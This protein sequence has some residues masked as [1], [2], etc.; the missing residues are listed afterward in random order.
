MKAAAWFLLLLTLACPCTAWAQPP[1]TALRLALLLFPDAANLRTISTM[2]KI[3][4]TE[5]TP[6]FIAGL[7]ARLPPGSMMAEVCGT[8]PFSDAGPS[9]FAQIGLNGRQGIIYEGPVSCEEGDATVLW[10]GP[11]PVSAPDA[12]QV[13]GDLLLIGDGPQPFYVD[14]IPGCCADPDSRYVYASSFD[15]FPES[16]TVREDLALPDGMA[17]FGYI[18]N[19]MIRPKTF[20]KKAFTLR[21]APMVDDTPSPDVRSPELRFGNILKRY[22]AGTWVT[23]LANWTDKKGLVWV[24]VSVPDDSAEQ[25]PGFIEQSYDLAN[26]GW[27]AAGPGVF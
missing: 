1:D 12:L 19:V 9:P 14:Y 18:G 17:N 3:T 26:I 25:K 16:F 21:N 5:I 23:G 2:Q 7:V 22:A 13:T 20:V 11:G 8:P 27:V 6:N 15:P 10:P 4:Q 24:L